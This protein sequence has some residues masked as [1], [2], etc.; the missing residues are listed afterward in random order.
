MGIIETLSAGFSLINRRLWLLS[1]PVL[2]DLLLWMGPEV[3]IA[4]FITRALLGYQSLVTQA[5][6]DLG[7]QSQVAP[8]DAGQVLEQIRQVAEPLEQS[9]LLGIL[10]WQMPSIV[11]DTSQGLGLKTTFYVEDGKTLLMALMSLA[12]SGLLLAS[13]FLSALAQFVRGERIAIGNFIVNIFSNWAKFAAY[14][15]LMAMALAILV[16]LALV[17]TGAIGLASPVVA[18]F[19]GAI[20]SGAMMWVALYLFFA[21]DAI[22]VTRSGPLGAV[23]N[24]ISVVRRNFWPSL[25]I[26]GIIN[27]ILWGTP[28]AWRLVMGHPLG[29]VAS[30]VGNA[31]IATGLT[32][33]SMIYYRQRYGSGG[34]S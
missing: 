13:V 32:A 24:S 17:L 22:F 28:L 4:P 27:V 19:V 25:G 7:P 30:I 29:I 18:S 33:A 12:A 21:N 34:R 20:F 5:A 26:F 31:Y 10:A 8:E 15:L 16:P 14:F 2:L 23:R 9:N 6:G 11:R 3:S 1:I